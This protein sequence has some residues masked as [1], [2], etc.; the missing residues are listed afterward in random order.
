[1]T[2]VRSVRNTTLASGRPTGS[3]TASIPRMALV[4]IQ[5]R[6]VQ[7]L[8]LG[9]RCRCLR[10]HRQEGIE[11]LALQPVTRRIRTC[12]DGVI[13]LQAVEQH[14]HVRIPLPAGHLGTK[15]DVLPT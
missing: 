15:I 3:A 13:L 4:P 7:L 8:L 10:L 5:E 2:P 6:F 1:M 14:V 11:A 9:A 12:A